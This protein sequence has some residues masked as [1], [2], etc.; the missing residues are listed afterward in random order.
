[1]RTALLFSLALSLPACFS[2][3][4]TSE[5]AE[6]EARIL[7]PEE[8]PKAERDAAEILDAGAL[9]TDPATRRRVLQM[10]ADELT[11]RLKA[12]T[13]ACEVEFRWRRGDEQ[14]KLSERAEL[15]QSPGG[16]FSVSVQNDRDFG[17]ELRY[18]GGKIF[19]RSRHGQFRER[20]SDRAGHEAWRQESLAQLSTFFRLIQGKATLAKVAEETRHGRGAVKYTLAQ[21]EG[22]D[23]A[24]LPAPLPEWL[25]EPQWPS[26]SRDAAT[27]QRAAVWE[28]AEL[29][30]AG[31][32]I[33]VDRLSVAVVAYKLSAKVRVPAPEDAPGLPATLTFTLSR[34]THGFGADKAIEVPEHL[35]FEARP[36]A[37]AEPLAWWPPW[38][39]AQEAAA[40]AE[41]A[42]AKGTEGA[43]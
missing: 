33:W 6:A 19:T 15:I 26:G 5:D 13:S 27:L 22:A 2:A 29:L 41:A 34:D 43:E 14:V 42:A 35:P 16:D 3:C 28:E 17:M 8:P 18:V 25:P 10:P 30:S 9:D 20:R 31:G 32:E 36:R 23:G 37:I 4:P 7:A 24:L 40:A 12:F 38:V 39:A 11:H 21:A 1:M